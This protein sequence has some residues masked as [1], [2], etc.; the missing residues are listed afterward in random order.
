MALRFLADHCISNFIVQTL[1]D[2]N[3]EVV[4]LRDV[5]PVESSDDVVNCQGPG[6]RCYSAFAERRF[7]RYRQ[8]PA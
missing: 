1:R 5:L 4:R 2:A 7:R 6:N 8:L 3:Y